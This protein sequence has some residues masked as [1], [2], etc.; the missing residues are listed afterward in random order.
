MHELLSFAPDATNP[1]TKIF[2]W[3]W[4]RIIMLEW[5]NGEDAVVVVLPLNHSEIRLLFVNLQKHGNKEESSD[6][7]E[8]NI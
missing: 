8:K 7:N 5:V 6:E 4:V 1:A 2:H 3:G